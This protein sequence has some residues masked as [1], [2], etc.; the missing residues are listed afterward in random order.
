MAW[1]PAKIQT[2]N[3]LK[4]YQETFPG[5]SNCLVDR[6]RFDHLKPMGISKKTCGITIS[7]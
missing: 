2:K 3:P 1:L 6:F 5:P 7:G 4:N